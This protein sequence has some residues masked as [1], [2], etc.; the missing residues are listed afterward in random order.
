[1][2]PPPLT[3]IYSDMPIPETMEK[4]QHLELENTVLRP[5]RSANTA[6][7]RRAASQHMTVPSH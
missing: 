1:V 4:M 6:A 7:A 5:A 3:P 2:I